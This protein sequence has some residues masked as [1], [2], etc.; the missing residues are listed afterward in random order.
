MQTMGNVIGYIL[1][2]AVVVTAVAAI[3]IYF[4]VGMTGSC[5]YCK[6]KDFMPDDNLTF[7]CN[8]CRRKFFA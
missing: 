4:Y 2:G 7:Y 3:A 5:P 6:S 8:N 1:F